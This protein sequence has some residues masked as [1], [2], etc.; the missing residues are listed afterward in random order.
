M[1]RKYWYA[2]WLMPNPKDATQILKCIRGPK[3]DLP[4]LNDEV[5]RVWSGHFDVE[6]LETRDP[7]RAKGILSDK[8][9]QKEGS[10]NNALGRV[11]WTSPKKVLT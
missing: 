9:A 6:E 7:Q 1:V 5:R 11:S 4:S 2:W 3:D 10:L 8:I